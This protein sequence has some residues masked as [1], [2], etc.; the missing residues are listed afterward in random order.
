MEMYSKLF[1]LAPPLVG[2]ARFHI[3]TFI[4]TTL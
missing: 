3:T 2:V 4:W 1:Y